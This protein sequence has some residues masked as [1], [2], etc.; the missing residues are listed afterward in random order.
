MENLA[1][2][3]YI[4]FALVGLTELPSVFIGEFL[5]NRVGRRWSQVGCMAIT[6]IIYAV[7]T[8][9]VSN[10]VS[11]TAITVMAITAKTASNVGWFIMWVQC[12]E[13]YPTSVRVTG[14]NLCALVA[15]IVCS[16]AP[17]VIYLVIIRT[18]WL[19]RLK[20]TS[21]LSPAFTR[22]C[23][24]AFMHLVEKDAGQCNAAG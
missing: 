13:L 5:I 11:G 24:N 4:N 22:L 15:N 10:D 7:I 21:V 6:A 17:Y 2:N 23:R 1:G 9:L 18:S 3:Q 12:V 19:A 8:G 16:A 20:I 14:S